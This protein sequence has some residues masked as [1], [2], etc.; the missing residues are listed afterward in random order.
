MLT[1]IATWLD[2]DSCVVWFQHLEEAHSEGYK[3]GHGLLPGAEVGGLLM[4]QDVFPGQTQMLERAVATQET[5]GVNHGQ[6]NYI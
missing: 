2:Q 3:V 4:G 1:H 6:G 5:E